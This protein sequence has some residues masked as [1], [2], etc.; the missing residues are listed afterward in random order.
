MAY[1]GLAEYMLSL[2]MLSYKIGK[3]DHGPF[4]LAYW[5]EVYENREKDKSI[6]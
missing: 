1:L 2:H 6:V 4:M 3:H 5:I